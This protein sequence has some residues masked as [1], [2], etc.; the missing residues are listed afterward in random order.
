M[1]NIYSIFEAILTEPEA[2]CL[3][4]IYGLSKK[5]VP[6]E[7]MDIDDYYEVYEMREFHEMIGR[8]ALIKY[9]KE[10]EMN[11]IEKLTNMIELVIE[12]Y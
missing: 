10:E 1:V 8:A 12:T 3:Y 11:F 5:E 9:K 7:V 2:E 4:G 6:D